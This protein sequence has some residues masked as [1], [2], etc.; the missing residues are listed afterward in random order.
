M[1]LGVK[2]LVQDAII[3]TRGSDASVGYDLYSVVDTTVPCQAGNALVGTGITVVLPP[4]CYGRVAPRSGLA[5]KH[6]I[7]V[8]AGVID[9]DYTGEIKVVL[10]NHGDKDFEVKKGDRIAQ[11]VL[12]K[13]DTPPIE[14]ISIVE[15]TER[16]SGGFGSTGK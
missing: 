8:G 13:C 1:S 16:G 11:L 6:C 12:E 14:E 3:P 7:Q 2:K 5:V 15:E 10:F 4:G 9:P